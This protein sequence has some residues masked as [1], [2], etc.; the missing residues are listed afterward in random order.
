MFYYVYVFV[1][2]NKIL[3]QL[4]QALCCILTLTYLVIFPNSVDFF[5]FL[6][7]TDGFFYQFDSADFF[8]NISFTFS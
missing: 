5:M 3:I 2:Q 7:F 1:S 4:L 8:A 6:I